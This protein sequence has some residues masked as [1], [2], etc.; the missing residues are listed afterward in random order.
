MFPELFQDL[1]IVTMESDNFID[2]INTLCQ[3]EAL[4]ANPIDQV[5]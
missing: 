4:S 2:C 1:R 3:E 5:R